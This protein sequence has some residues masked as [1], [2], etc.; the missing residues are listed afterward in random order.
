M[1]NAMLFSCCISGMAMLPG[2]ASAQQYTFVSIDVQCSATADASEC[3][4]GL[5]PSQVAAQTSAKGIN[6]RGDVVGVYVAGGKQRGFLLTD[7]EYTSLEFPLPGVRVTVANGINAHGEIVGQYT[8]PVHDPN[9]PPPEDSPLYCPS[10]ADPACIKGFHYWRGQFTTV[11]FPSTVDENGQTHAHPGAIAQRITDDGAIY[12]C[13]HDHDLGQSMFGA[14]WARSGASSLMFSG[15]ELSDPM[16]VPMSM[17]NG[18]TPGNGKTIVGFF[19]DMSNRQHGYVVRDRMLEPYDPTPATTLTAIWDVNPGQQF[20]GTFRESGEVA[21]KRHAFLQSPDS[22]LPITFDFTC[23]EP[24]GCAGAP[25]GTVAFATVAFGV[26]SD[27]VIVGQYQLMNGG[28]PHG[29]VAIP[30]DAN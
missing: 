12:G 2:Q 10:A 27:A 28:A 25:T 11:V 15:G 29:F 9:N 30:A 3:P 13:V 24:T 26:N 23:Q 16:A 21:A 6:A 22:S 17:N 18:G 5:A 19:M 1:K 8:L 4:A 7:G 20:V 14:V